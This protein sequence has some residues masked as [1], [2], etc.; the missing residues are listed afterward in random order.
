MFLEDILDVVYKDRSP[1]S[2]T[3]C[4]STHL[5]S[6]PPAQYLSIPRTHSPSTVR[7]ISSLTHA[8]DI[9]IEVFVD[10]I[11][12]VLG[13]V[14]LG[15]VL[16]ILPSWSDMVQL[17]DALVKQ[18]IFNKKTILILLHATLTSSV[19]LKAFN[20]PNTRKVFLSTSIVESSI[21]VPDVTCVI[22]SGVD[23]LWVHQDSNT[24]QFQKSWISKQSVVY[25]TNL[26]SSKSDV[27]HICVRMYTQSGYRLFAEH[28]QPEIKR[29]LLDHICLQT[30]C[31][32]FDP[33]QVLQWCPNRPL[34]RSIKLAMDHLQKIGA[35][36]EA[37][38]TSL[39]S[40]MGLLSI[41]TK[42]SR[43]LVMGT[44]FQCIQPTLT[45]AAQLLT[46]TSCF[47]PFS[48]SISVCEVNGTEHTDILEQ[49]EVD[50]VM[51]FADGLGSVLLAFVVVFEAWQTSIFSNTSRLF[52]A[53]HNLSQSYLTVIASIRQQLQLMMI[54]VGLLP[55]GCDGNHRTNRKSNN[56]EMLRVVLTSSLYPKI[57][58]V[59]TA[60]SVPELITCDGQSVQCNLSA[61]NFWR[62]RWFGYWTE[63]V[64][65][66]LS[67]RSVS[68]V[69][70]L[71]LALFGQTVLWCDQ[72]LS[73]DNWANI[74]ASQNI[75]DGIRLIREAI[76]TVLSEIFDLT[77]LGE[78]C[79][80]TELSQHHSKLDTLAD[81]IEVLVQEIVKHAE[82]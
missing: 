12:H 2:A 46:Q 7:F 51:S 57:A 49:G 45:I 28:S 77:G 5:P 62:H 15:N 41:P 78:W 38:V 44:L 11:E 6:S 53:N 50:S 73:I 18:S 74:C 37:G 33:F 31:F 71:G 82:V 81:E 80:S 10:V 76:F 24:A 43:M 25:R 64:N 23:E 29:V 72:F 9:P 48:S 22:D 16:V 34:E 58:Y 21:C 55:R 8:M 56:M 63:P 27:Q 4:R 52:C 59:K 69:S 79:V 32:S 75:A 1:P 13:V 17:R 26:F 40:R 70:P 36:T 3:S 35:I 42:L 65:L 19:V 61:D 67:P 60:T 54:D 47:H 14:K 20:L 68:M 66:E 39:G 30:Q